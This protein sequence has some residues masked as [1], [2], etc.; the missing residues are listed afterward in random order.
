MISSGIK[1][2]MFRLVAQCLNQLR[3]S[4]PQT[5]ITT[6]LKYIFGSRLLALTVVWKSIHTAEA[7]GV[8]QSIY[9]YIL[10]LMRRG[11]ELQLGIYRVSTLFY[12]ILPSS[13]HLVL[14][15]YKIAETATPQHEHR[16]KQELYITACSPK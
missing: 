1:P 2:E 14:I 16:Q 12:I 11:S 10:S 3:Y 15:Y 4:V 8:I 5:N 6:E 13:V 9:W 7:D